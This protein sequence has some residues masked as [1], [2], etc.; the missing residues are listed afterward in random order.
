MTATFVR[1]R[2]CSILVLILMVTALLGASRAAQVTPPGGIQGTIL[3]NQGGAVT[4]AR[5]VLTNK[6]TGQTL[7][8]PVNES[9]TYASGALKPGEYQVR[10]EAAGFNTAELKVTVEVGVIS[11]GNVSLE[12]GSEKTVVAVESSVVAVNEEQ[13]TV[14]G[15]LTS[16]QIESLPING[17]NFLDLAP[18]RTRRADPGRRQF[19]S[20]Q[21]RL[22]FHLL[23]GSLRPH[24][25]YRSRWRRHQRR[26]RRHHHAKHSADLDS[27]ISDRPVE[28]RPLHRADLHGY[29]ERGHSLRHQRHPRRKLFSWR[30][31]SVSA[32]LGSL[33]SPFDRKQFGA[34]LGGISMPFLLGQR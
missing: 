2:A 22:F 15:V 14:Q 3:D 16:Q 27:R 23:R 9:G 28:P 10:V 11:S 21:E 19:R 8:V 17:R 1:T 7:T 4:S 32:K 26:N 33:P 31:D 34:R 29:G 20:H 12:V 25:A 5:V 13:A 6:A 30:G 18:A 24:H